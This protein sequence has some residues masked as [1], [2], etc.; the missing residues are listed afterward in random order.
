M[1]LD[2][3]AEQN[4]LVEAFASLFAKHA[5]S[6][7][8]RV[9][10]PL[11]F[12]K[13]LWA[14]LHEMG[15][16]EMALDESSGGWGASP[17]DLVLIAEQQGRSVAPAPIIETQVAARLLASVGEGR[18][19]EVL[20][21]AVAGGRIVTLALHPAAHGKA[22]LVPAAAIADDAL[23]LDGDRLLLVS[24]DGNRTTVE[25]LASMPLA[26]VAVPS[27]AE[28]IAEGAS[29]LAAHD[30]A[31]DD[32]LLLTS[33]AVVGM[34]ARTLEQALEYVKER[35]AWGTPIGAFQSVAHRF[36]D[37]ATDIDGA[38]LL[39]YEAAWAVTDQPERAAELAALAFGFA[40]EAVK[41]ASL[42]SLHYHGGY[43]FMNEYDAQLYWRRARGWPGV[44]GEPRL[45]F[46]RAE[47]RR[48]ARLDS[49]GGVS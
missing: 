12:D 36:A 5:T 1:D 17:L 3:C 9:A 26:D 30:A 31:I 47:R 29:A 38:R 44:W 6:E 19:A 11:G 48:I 33:A 42:R 4:Q 16:L 20:A 45:A 22:T 34:G 23:I 27:D 35:K 24:L 10:E 18:A 37:S 49:N 40:S 32:F 8:V 28:V 15:I 39:C 7:Q 25:N 43:G 41:T 13:A 14:Q 2:L 46:A 21:D